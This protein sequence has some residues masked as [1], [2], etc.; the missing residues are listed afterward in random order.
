MGEDRCPAPSSALRKLESR[1]RKKERKE[2]KR[3]GKRER[4]RPRLVAVRVI[5][6]VR[7]AE[8]VVSKEIRIIKRA[9]I[10]VIV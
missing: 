9:Y 3:G 8:L 4:G 10:Q 1:K 6:V 2:G 5:V 7:G